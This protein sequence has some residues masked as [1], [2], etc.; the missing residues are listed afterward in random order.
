M[1][2]FGPGVASLAL[3]P[4]SGR[5]RAPSRAIRSRYA[6]RR[7][8][9]GYRSSPRSRLGASAAN[10]L[11]AAA[12]R[13]V[14]G[15]AFRPRPNKRW[16]FS[17]PPSARS[18]LM[19]EP[20]GSLASPSLPY[21]RCCGALPIREQGVN[22]GRRRAAG[23]ARED[24]ADRR[25]PRWFRLLRRFPQRGRACLAILTYA[26]RTLRLRVGRLGRAA[27]QPT[28]RCHTADFHLPQCASRYFTLVLQGCDNFHASEN[29]EP[30]SME[31]SD[32]AGAV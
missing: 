22:C 11:P 24:G 4:P 26:R 14:F 18:R 3:I 15:L 7:F 16:R 20:L 32:I 9:A 27:R 29:G 2:R 13:S 31:G 19:A 12:L 17:S 8:V 1:A 23:G 25:P 10:R 5:K 21:W 30:P 28:P 6:S